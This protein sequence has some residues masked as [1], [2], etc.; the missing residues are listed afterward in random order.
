MK[1]TFCEKTVRLVPSAAE[2]ASVSVEANPA[3]CGGAGTREPPLTHPLP[4]PCLIQTNSTT[5]TK[6]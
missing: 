4:T 6:N 2:P 5:T 1:C 3:T